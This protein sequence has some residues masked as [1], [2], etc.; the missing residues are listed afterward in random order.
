MTKH[1]YSVRVELD[2]VIEA[3]VWAEDEDTAGD[4]GEVIGEN[5]LVNMMKNVDATFCTTGVKTIEIETE[6]DVPDQTEAYTDG[7]VT[8]TLD[9]GALLWNDAVENAGK[10][11]RFTPVV[12]TGEEQ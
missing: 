5:I 12:E 11:L 1:P 10:D 2:T 6:E 4:M 3:M 9:N 8:F 7:G